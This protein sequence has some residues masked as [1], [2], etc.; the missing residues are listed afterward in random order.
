MEAA[1]LEKQCDSFLNA[2]KLQDFHDFITKISELQLQEYLLH[3]TDSGMN[4]IYLS[5]QQP[6]S[7]LTS[8]YVSTDLEVTVY[9]KQQ[10]LPPSCYKHILSTNKVTL[11]SQIINLMAYAKNAQESNAVV[12]ETLQSNISKLL[13]DLLFATENDQ[14]MPCLKFV[15]EQFVA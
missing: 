7:I 13:E 10:V 11:F 4:L 1:R 9:L 3:Q 8:I 2:D 6:L 12:L 14:I 5:A 15:I